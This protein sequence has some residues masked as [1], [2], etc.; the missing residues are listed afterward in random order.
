MFILSHFFL[1][2]EFPLR[3][4]LFRWQSSW[5]TPRCPT[6]KTKTRY[7]CGKRL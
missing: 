3:L 6:E 2:L 5:K 4:R 1:H 7:A